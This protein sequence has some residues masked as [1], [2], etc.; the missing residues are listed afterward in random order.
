MCQ[1]TLLSF[2]VSKDKGRHLRAKRSQ[3][4]AEQNERLICIG[5]YK[6]FFFKYNIYKVFLIMKGKIKD[7][8]HRCPIEN[9]I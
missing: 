6:G 7:L 4:Y 2:A 3:I 8:Y 1:Q 5:K 9:R